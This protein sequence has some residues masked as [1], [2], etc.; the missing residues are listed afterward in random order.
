MKEPLWQF[1][2]K[3]FTYRIY[4]HIYSYPSQAGDWDSS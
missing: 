4:T 1:R 3:D 2:N